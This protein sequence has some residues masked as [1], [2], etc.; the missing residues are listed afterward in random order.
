MTTVPDFHNLKL[1]TAQANA[2]NYDILLTVKYEA[3]SEVEEGRV[4]SQ[5]IDPMEKVEKNTLVEIVVSNGQSPVRESSIKITLGS[6]A[7]GEFV[8]KYYIDGILQEDMTETRDIALSKSIVWAMSGDGTADYAIT[9][10]STV[11]GATDTLVNMTIDFT[12][13][14]P[15]KTQNEFNANVFKQ[16]LSADPVT[17]V[18]T[19]ATTPEVTTPEVTEATSEESQTEETSITW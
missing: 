1:A 4:I 16:L 8:F 12:T 5:S 3:S 19:E 18:A 13:D 10:T 9:V 14:P 11:T 6:S 7:T 17:T 2:E 15:T